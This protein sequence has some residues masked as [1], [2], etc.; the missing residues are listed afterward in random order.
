MGRR[1][2]HPCS[3]RFTLKQISSIDVCEGDT[4]TGNADRM[5]NCYSQ[6]G[7]I[8][9]A[10]LKFPSLLPLTFGFLWLG[11]PCTSRQQTLPRALWSPLCFLALIFSVCCPYSLACSPLSVQSFTPAP[12]IPFMY[13]FMLPPLYLVWQPSISSPYSA[14][15][16]WH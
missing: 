7:L 6:L 11:C 1:I 15:L 16:E 14:H 5:V 12:S 3:T 4:G 9:L 10:H 8:R 13:F 2:T